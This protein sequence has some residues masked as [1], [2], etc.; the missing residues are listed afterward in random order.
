MFTEYQEKETTPVKL[1]N[2]GSA[3]PLVRV[4]VYVAGKHSRG[5]GVVWVNAARVPLVVRML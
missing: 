2:V 4:A 1:M 3:A 5:L